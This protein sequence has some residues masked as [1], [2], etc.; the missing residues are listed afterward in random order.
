M[1]AL[2]A[3]TAATPESLQASASPASTTPVSASVQEDSVTTQEVTTT[4]TREGN[5]TRDKALEL[6]GKNVPNH[7]TAAILG[8]T[9]ARVSQFL[10]DPDF[11]EQVQARLI[12]STLASSE[13]DKKKDDIEDL[14]LQKMQDSIGFITRP[15]EIL[16]ALQVVSALPRRAAA[17]Q[18][19]PTGER[20]EATLTLPA[21]VAKGAV[22]VEFQFN[23]DREVVEVGGKA[24]QTMSMPSVL[25]ALEEY[26]E[27]RNAGASYNN[28]II[29]HSPQDTESVE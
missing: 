1:A 23:T 15:L 12:E 27:T 5:S 4:T 9:P 10:E 28:D 2:L 16:K 11:K 7:T 29:E 8:I 20:M 25:S 3:S 14:L 22:K 18:G 24:M 6:L 17:T 26:K 21:F 19:V 13:R